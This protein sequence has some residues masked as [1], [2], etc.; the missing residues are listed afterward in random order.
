MT[1]G[2]LRALARRLAQPARLTRE[3]RDAL[4]RLT[5]EDVDV[6]KI[7][8]SIFDDALRGGQTKTRPAWR[9]WASPETCYM[10]R[11]CLAGMLE[12]I[13]K[14]P[15]RGGIVLSGE[16]VAELLE[17]VVGTAGEGSGKV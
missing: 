7:A 6:L 17:I 10:V 9:W 13:E 15:A 5:R 4:V 12:Q 8:R 3:D 1:K 14:G 2:E 16:G 11:E